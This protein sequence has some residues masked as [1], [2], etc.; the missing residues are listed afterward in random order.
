MSHWGPA[1][2]KPGSAGTPQ[3][4]ASSDTNTGTLNFSTSP[5]N[6]TDFM[7]GHDFTTDA[8]MTSFYPVAPTD[9]GA[10]GIKFLGGDKPTPDFFTAGLVFAAGTTYPSVTPQITSADNGAVWSSNHLLLKSTGTTTLTLNSFP[11]YGTT[12]YGSL[13]GAGI[14]NDHGVI[15]PASVE[16]GFLPLGDSPATPTPIYQP[17]VTQLTVNGSWLIPGQTYTLELQYSVIG[18]RPDEVNLNGVEWQGVS[19]Y[20]KVTKISLSTPAL[21]QADFNGDGHPDLIWQNTTTGDRG[22]WL[23]NGTTVLSGVMIA[24]NVPLEWKIAGA[25]DFNGDGHPDLIW[26]NTTTGDVGVWLMNG[27]TVLSG[28]MIATN[29]PLEWKIAGAADFNEDG[30]PDLIWQNTT[31]GDRGVWLMN[32]TT[33]LSGVMIATNVP[34]EWQIAGT[35]DFNGDGHPDLIWQNTTTGDRG[36]WL[37]N[38]TTALSGE[39]IATNVPLEWQIVNY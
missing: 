33:A 39:M 12:T 9:G 3:S 2:Y 23:M 20:R 36:V 26:Q 1:F 31:T 29:V 10:Y 28:V 18:G 14:Y 37:M 5:N 34:L 25:A 11:E 19:T 16:S 15:G 6:G 7:F 22:V 17:P 35:D 21:L 13:I 38:G 30:H 8:A 4:G 27:T 32:G 24:T